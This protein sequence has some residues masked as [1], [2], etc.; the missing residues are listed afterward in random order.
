MNKPLTAHRLPVRVAI[1]PLSWAN[2]VIEEFGKDATAEGCLLGALNAGYQG[3]EMSRLFPRHPDQLTTL[4]SRYQLALASG[5]HSG[6]LAEG[7]VEQ[8]LEAVAEF[9]A[10]LK[11]TGARVLVYGECAAMADNALDVPMSRRLRLSAE[12]M[13]AYGA[14]LTGF[15]R[16]L[17]ERYGLGLAYHHH[18]MMVVETHDELR[19]LMAAT[20]NEV[21]LLLD[22]GHALAGGFSYVGLIDEFGPRI[23]HIHLKDVRAEVLQR[24]RS[25]DLSFN[26]A[27]RAGMFTIPGDG[28]IDFQPLCDFISRSGYDGWLVVEAEQDPALERPEIT[29]ARARDYLSTILPARA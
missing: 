11:K 6:M 9:A 27:V 21:G 23:K 26:D 14:R 2:E 10:L 17:M 20:G 16:Q 25:D 15:A 5:W 8:E 19:Q 7:S 13:A 12:Q 18:L 28:V 3:V 4:L 24:V 1:S 22:T 29:V